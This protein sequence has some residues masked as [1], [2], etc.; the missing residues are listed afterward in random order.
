LSI[1]AYFLLCIA[2][3]A[4][5][6]QRPVRA[7]AEPS[8]LPNEQAPSPGSV[9]V[10]GLIRA[11]RVYALQT[12]QIAQ[13]S[14][15]GGGMGNRLTL[16]TLVPNGA[17]VKQGDVVAEFDNTRQLDETLEVQAKYDDLGHQV[18]QKVALNLSEAEKRLQDLKQA[19]ADLAKALIQL[20]KGPVLADVDRVKN[21][22]K[23]ESAR[24]RVESLK[25]SHAARERA[26]AASVRI[27]EL[28]QERQKVA[29]ERSKANA[30]KLVVRAPLGGMI[31]LENIWKGGSMGH[32]L[33]GDMLWP[34]QPLL[35]IF[36]PSEMIVDAQ[37]GEPDNA[38]LTPGALAQVHLDAYPGVTFDAV[39]ESASPVATTALGSPVKNFGAR[40]RLRGSDPR[41]LPDLSAA[42]VLADARTAP[43]SAP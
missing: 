33:E 6:Q 38:R 41:L 29:L 21:E 9:R 7:A 5:C 30:E 18:K 35:K 32:P 43:G 13:V 25:R 20:K 39:F 10:T 3:L 28:Q 26:E 27:L 2:L 19:E 22:I 16:V 40:F 15:G 36:D 24:S 23:A 31:A 1:N 4:G 14:Q 42:V 17:R 8:V 37:V 11:V 34:G 12:P